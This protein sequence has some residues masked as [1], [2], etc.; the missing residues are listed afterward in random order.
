MTYPETPGFQAHS[1]TSRKAAERLTTSDSMEKDIYALLDAYSNG[2]TGDELAQ[3][4][5]T[6]GYPGVQTGTVAARLRGLELK[7]RAVK[8]QEARP[9]R[10][11]RAAHVWVTPR[12]AKDRHKAAVASGPTVQE[13]Q[14]Q[15]AKLS[16]KI[17]GLRM[18]TEKQAEDGGLWFEAR[19]APEAYLQ[20][21]LRRL[22]A[23]IERPITGV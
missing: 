20:Q 22:H 3:Y 19:T 21:E 18:L 9:T 14:Q 17:Y 8:L 4:L 15:V 7:G 11:G 12:L 16:L 5:D 10:S 23:A 6:R 2:W 13:L 1:E